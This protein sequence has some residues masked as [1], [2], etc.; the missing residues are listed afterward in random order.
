MESLLPDKGDSASSPL[1]AHGVA[2]ELVNCLQDLEKGEYL[3]CEAYLESIVDIDHDTDETPLMCWTF[4][5]MAMVLLERRDLGRSVIWFERAFEMADDKAIPHCGPMLE[6]LSDIAKAHFTI[7]KTHAG[8]QLIV[9]QMENEIQA[10]EDQLRAVLSRLEQALNQTRYERGAIETSTQQD[11][12]KREM[13]QETLF[14][15]LLGSFDMRKKDGKRVTL[16]ANRKGQMIFKFLASSEKKRCHK[17]MLLSTFWPEDDPEDAIGKLH[18]AI[19]R[20]RRSLA[21]AEIGNAIV[22]ENDAYNLC[23]GQQI[24]TDV[25]SFDLHYRA[26]NLYLAN[27]AVDDAVKEFE[28]ALPLYRGSYLAEIIGEDWPIQERMRLEEQYLHLL[29]HLSRWHY[30]SGSFQQTIDL[31]HKLL[32]LDDLRE[33]VYRLLMRALHKTGHRNQALRVYEDLTNLLKKELSVEPMSATQK[34]MTAI[35]NESDI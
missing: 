23:P 15:R 12:Q 6:A 10:L 14:V 20:L 29:S 7:F 16:C 2:V 1:S 31:C 27:G 21:N 22:Y 5:Q 35:R 30:E 17:E 11:H 19:S 18:I 33:D 26:G 4:L 9:N 34:L 25:S 28:Q 32:A 3:G 8:L 13:Y 24:D